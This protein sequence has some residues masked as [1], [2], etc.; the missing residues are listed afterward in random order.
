[1]THYRRVCTI[2]DLEENVGYEVILKG[3]PLALFLS[4]GN[5][6]AVDDRC[7]HREGQL[8]QGWVKNGEA[9]CPLHQWN[10]DLETGVSPYNPHDKIKTYPVMRLRDDVLVDVD[11]VD[12]I[13][14]ASF[15][16]YQGRWRRWS[17]DSRG[18]QEVRKIAKGIITSIEAMGSTK[19]FESSL[20]FDHFNLKAGQLARQPLLEDEQVSVKTS[21]GLNTKN[22]LS[23]SLPAYIAHMSF[24]ALSKRAKVAL[25]KGS[26]D[27]DTLICSGEGG[28][29]P[30]ER[31]AASTYI[32]EMASGYFGWNE[33]AIKK[34]DGFEIKIGQSAKPGMG[35]ELPGDKV[36]GEIA[37]IRGLQEGVAAHSPSRFPDINSIDEMAK[38]IADI[39][40]MAPGKPVGIKF[41]A[42]DIE[43]DMKT[44][45]SLK[46][47]FI[48]I[49]GFGGGTG[50]APT[51]IRDHFGMSIVRAIPIA[52]KMINDSGERITLVAT[53]GIRTP[54]DI[55]KAIAL[56]ADCCAL[57]TSSL[58]A[59]GC[60]Y[61][62]ACGSGNCPTGIATQDKKL[63]KRIDK[64]IGAER[65]ANFYNGTRTILEQYLRV[66]GYRDISEIS[67]ED[68][69]P[70]TAEATAVLNGE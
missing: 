65:V 55:I 63:S 62:R 16:G 49:D 56:G 15:S 9:I 68:L 28:M 34:A 18:K 6:Y 53:G 10:F 39:R 14:P 12:P 44:A 21:I 36:K 60:E 7:P 47:D 20:S 59:L 22:P 41:A 26:A 35:G 52:R 37:E 31:E 67:L 24:G 33:D 17:D 8:S 48:T 50:S 30:K 5:I 29:H 27:A 25:A 58:F 1:M 45:I 43:N 51:H 32:L 69:I 61:Y 40:K 54:A 70:M 57:A 3:H 64:N 19:S 13:P 2:S 11:S 38:R 46:P 42:N 23:I 4:N 66:M